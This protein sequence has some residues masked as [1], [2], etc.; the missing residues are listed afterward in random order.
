MASNAP[1]L[2]EVREIIAVHSAKGGVGK[3]TTAA[4][5]AVTLARLGLDVGVLDADI[6]GPSIAHLFGDVGQPMASPR[7]Q[8]ALP[9]QRHGVKF[10]SLTN[11]TGDDA[12]VIWRGPMVSSALG[13]MLGMV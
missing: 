12:P 3:S 2:T 13:E 9:L 11:V 5:L 10:L 4:N 7:V 8:K 6:H 1:V